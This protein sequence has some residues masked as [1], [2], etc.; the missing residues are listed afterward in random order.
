MD[1]GAKRTGD[2]GGMGWGTCM[3]FT[4]ERDCSDEGKEAWREEVVLVQWDQ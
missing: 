2:D 4:C 1:E 3:I